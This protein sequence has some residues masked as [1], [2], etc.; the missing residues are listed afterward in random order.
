MLRY[1][2]EESLIYWVCTTAQAME[3]AINEELASHN[4]TYRQWQALGWLVFEG[5]L[6]QCE[7]AERMRVEPPTLAGIVERM[8]RDG[9]IER[10]PCPDD[11]RRKLLRPT[12]RVEPVWE[13]IAAAARR[14]RSRAAE[15]FDEAERRRLMAA[16][17]QIRANLS[18]PA[19]AE[20]HQR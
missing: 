6:S 2:F 15:G 16:L 17:E 5:E 8:E 3:K 7:L 11:R 10:V 1:D 12:G 13:T 18:A 4:I 20:E 9:W 19:L 14:V